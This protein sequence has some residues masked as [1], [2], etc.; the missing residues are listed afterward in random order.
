LFDQTEKRSNLDIDNG[1]IVIMLLEST[2]KTKAP[3][4]A[5]SLRQLVIIR[6]PVFIVG[7]PYSQE[8]KMSK[9]P[10]L[11]CSSVV[12][13]SVVSVS[14]QRVQLHPTLLALARTLL[15][16]NAACLKTSLLDLSMPG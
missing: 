5:S 10:V 14:W 11:H 7:N 12:Q 8:M 1:I 13:P 9:N 16:R 4:W 3:E 6:K 2:K 15:Y